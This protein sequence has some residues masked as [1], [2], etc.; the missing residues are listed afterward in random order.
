MIPRIVTSLILPIFL[1]ASACSTSPKSSSDQMDLKN[2]AQATVTKFR[3]ADPGIARLM[4]S[5]AG[6][7]VF[8]T[9]GKGGAGVGGATGR[10]VLYAHGQPVGYCRMT[11]ATVGLQLGGQTYSEMILFEDDYALKKFQSSEWAMAAQA[12]AVAAASGAAANAKYRDGV[13]VF[14]IGQEGLMGEAAVGGQKFRF[15]PM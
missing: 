10:G 9:I 1:L 11:Q 12:S 8:P 15:E 6:Y 14:V 13:M 4:D 2:E 3:N 5:A 7:A